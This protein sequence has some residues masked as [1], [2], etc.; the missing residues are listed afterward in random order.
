MSWSLAFD[1]V[2]LAPPS[3]VWAMYTFQTLFGSS[4][5]FGCAP[6]PP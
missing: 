5:G 4:C 3:T 6:M 2:Q 1:V